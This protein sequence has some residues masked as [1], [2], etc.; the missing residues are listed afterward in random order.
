MKTKMKKKSTYQYYDISGW[1]FCSLFWRI[2]DTVNC[3]RDLLNF[4]VKLSWNKIW[5]QRSSLH[6]HNSLVYL[7]L[8]SKHDNG[9]HKKLLIEIF[10]LL[11][12]C[13]LSCLENVTKDFF[14]FS[15]RNHQWGLY[16]EGMLKLPLSLLL[17]T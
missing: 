10:W 4:K 1:F 14:L 15:Y 16:E 9:N 12:D 6:G 2:E 17:L 3:I 7:L 11:R 13:K 5:Q 8:T